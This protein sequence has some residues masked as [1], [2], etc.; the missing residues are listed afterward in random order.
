MNSQKYR[1]LQR[2]V[3]TTLERQL[4]INKKTSSRQIT[5][6]D[7]QKLYEGQMVDVFQGEG[8]YK[9]VGGNVRVARITKNPK[10]GYHIWGSTPMH[11]VQ[12]SLEELA[13]QVFRDKIGEMYPIALERSKKL[14]K[15]GGGVIGQDVMEQVRKESL[16]SYTLFEP[17]CGDGRVSFAANLVYGMPTIG[18]DIDPV[19][20]KMSRENLSILRK[21]SMIKSRKVKLVQGDI[22]DEYLLS[23][24]LTDRENNKNFAVYLYMTRP[25]TIKSMITMLPYLQENDYVINYRVRLSRSWL[26]VFSKRLEIRLELPEFMGPQINVYRVK[27]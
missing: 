1:L 21:E 7:L 13:K 19:M 6:D 26:G 2:V 17:G 16:A 9:L 25:N 20:I 22:F 8:F 27:K 5:L 10:G 18:V 23:S 14:G 4:S 15:S 12:E 11:A 24:F 3:D